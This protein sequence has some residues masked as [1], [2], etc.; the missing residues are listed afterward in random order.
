MSNTIVKTI[1]SAVKGELSTANGEKSK[2]LKV[3]EAKE[4]NTILIKD[5]T[6]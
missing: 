2:M 1:T 4:S 6:R 3:A 5:L